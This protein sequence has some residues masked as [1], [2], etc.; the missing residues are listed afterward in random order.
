MLI[1]ICEDSQSDRARLLYFLNK[2]RN[3]TGSVFSVHW[4]ASADKMLDEYEKSDQKPDIIFLDIYMSGTDGMSAA[5][6]LAEIGCKSGIIFTTSSD[7]HAL[8]AF[9]VN[10]DGYLLKPYTYDQLKR[11]LDRYSS[12]F[13]ASRKTI[14]VTFNREETVIPLGNIR[15]VESYNHCT[16]FYT[17]DKEYKSVRP[18]SAFRAS[19][20][21]EESFI[22][23]GKSNIVN[24]NFIKKCENGVIF[25]DNGREIPIPVRIRKSVE[26]EVAS[27]LDSGL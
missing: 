5:E 6:K 22:C 2:F 23:C 21:L 13:A 3:E 10:A 11:T 25:L 27:Y 14:T 8:S 16:Y 7:S 20:C 26:R 1:Y 4:F 17:L 19:F 15:S 24:L 12:A 9:R 18:I